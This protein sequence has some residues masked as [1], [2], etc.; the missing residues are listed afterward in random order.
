MTTQA[1]PPVL[2]PAQRGA[3]LLRKTRRKALDRPR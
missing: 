3:L 2:T 1:T